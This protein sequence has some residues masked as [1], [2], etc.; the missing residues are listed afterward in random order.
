MQPQVSPGSTIEEGENKKAPKRRGQFL[1]LIPRATLLL[2]HESRLQEK[3]LRLFQKFVK[4]FFMYMQI[5]QGKKVSHPLKSF[6]FCGRKMAL[7]FPQAAQKT[8]KPALPGEIP[9]RSRAKNRVSGGSC[10]SR[11]KTAGPQDPA[12]SD[13]QLQAAGW[14]SSPNYA[15]YRRANPSI[16]T[17]PVPSNKRLPGSGVCEVNGSDV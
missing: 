4:Y 16:P 17:A 6:G 11:K 2:S 5:V 9:L 13:L 10:A 3:I 15:K 8:F 1:S 14:A 7:R 12:V